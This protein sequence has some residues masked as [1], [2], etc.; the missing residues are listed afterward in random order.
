MNDEIF[1]ELIKNNSIFLH[2]DNY[3]FVQIGDCI[4]EFQKELEDTG[5]MLTFQYHE[6]ADE[7]GYFYRINAVL[8]HKR[9]NE[10][11]NKIQN[12]FG[13]EITNY[14]TIHIK[15]DFD[16]IPDDLEHDTFYQNISYRIR[17]EKDILLFLEFMKS[18]Y[19]QTA[20]PFFEKYKTIDDVN[21]QLQKILENKVIQS[22]LTDSGGNSAILRYYTIGLICKNQFVIDFFENIYFPYIFQQTDRLSVEEFNYLGLLKNSIK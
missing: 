3:K 21:D 20:V 8:A 9:F 10:I 2:L 19:Y 5:Y 17:D 15:P 11:E 1:I 13:G 14:Y 4:I 7:K 18:F 16:M 6:S 22:L 12:L